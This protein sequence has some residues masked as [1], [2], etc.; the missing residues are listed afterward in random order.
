MKFVLRGIAR[1][2]E[3]LHIFPVRRRNGQE[4]KLRQ[5]YSS[6]GHNRL[7]ATFNLQNRLIVIDI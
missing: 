7:R 6:T 2:N 4:M 3:F 5:S 1:E